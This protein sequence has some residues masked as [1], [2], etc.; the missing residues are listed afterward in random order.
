MCYA[1]SIT[2]TT[3]ASARPMPNNIIFTKLNNGPN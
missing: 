3:A 2:C 1:D